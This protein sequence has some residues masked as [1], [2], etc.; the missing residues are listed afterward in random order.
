MIN[1]EDF[2]KHVKNISSQKWKS[3]FDLLPD[4]YATEKFGELIEPT[5]LENGTFTF[6]YWKS[7]PIVTKTF[8][9]IEE[10][11]LAPTFDYIDWDEGSKIL[12]DRSLNYS[13]MDIITLCKLL[14][15][16]IRINRFSESAFMHT[17]GE[18][19]MQ[20]ILEG[21][22]IQVIRMRID[23]IKKLVDKHM[24]YS[25]PPKVNPELV[26]EFEETHKVK[27]PLAYILF[28]TEI[29]DGDGI[30]FNG[31]VPFKNIL[32][33]DLDLKSPDSLLNPS[34]PFL[35]TSEWNP[36]FK[37]TV[38][39]E[40]NE[41]EHYKEFSSFKEKSSGS[42]EMNGTVALYNLGSGISGHLVVNGK[43]YGNIWTHNRCYNGGIYP[44]KEFGNSGKIDF[45][46]VCEQWLTSKFGLSRED[47]GP[48]KLWWKFW[49]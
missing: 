34:E 3:L 40:E 18:G 28:L 37:P 30:R 9:T 48:K 42:R 46:D 2:D 35:H 47:I 29:C 26:K 4:I 1:L 8:D 24:I 38:K 36:V 27:L 39:R 49:K 43:E 23:R 31:L 32:F 41:E 33:N 6:P 44:T 7:A 11:N 19:T 13:T 10:L 17:F 20:K 5:R 16:V 21:L 12:N 22:Q 15:I 45:L 25:L 14:T